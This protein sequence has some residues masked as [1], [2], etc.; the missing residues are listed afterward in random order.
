M[1][2]YIEAFIF[3][4]RGGQYRFALKRP[5]TEGAAILCESNPT[6]DYYFADCKRIAS[7]MH[8]LKSSVTNMLLLRDLIAQ[9]LAAHT[10]LSVGVLVTSVKKD[11]RL[12]PLDVSNDIR[13][14]FVL[15]N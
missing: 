14:E 3:I 13:F 15:I 6:Y 1:Y 10:P 4:P 2:K 8:E 7:T 5:V 11:I 12:Y 9:E